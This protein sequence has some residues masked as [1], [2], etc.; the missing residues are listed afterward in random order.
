[1]ENRIIMIINQQT[2]NKV[3]LIVI[4]YQLRG[5][6]IKPNHLKINIKNVKYIQF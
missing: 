3:Q 6:Y 2:N 1:M 5:L 4:D